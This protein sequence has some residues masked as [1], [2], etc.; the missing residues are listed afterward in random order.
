M[1]FSDIEGDKT[2]KARRKRGRIRRKRPAPIHSDR[3][4]RP[5]HAP[6]FAPRYINSVTRLPDSLLPKV[7]MQI[8]AMSTFYQESLHSADNLAKEIDALRAPDRDK[9]IEAIKKEVVSLITETKTLIPVT[10]KDYEGKT[11][12]QAQGQESS[13]RRH[14]ISALSQSRNQTT[15]IVLSNSNP[16]HLR[17]DSSDCFRYSTQTLSQYSS[18]NWRKKSLRYVDSTH[19][20]S[21]R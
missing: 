16:H 4:L 2:E 12:W 20:R 10:I 17:T 14:S 5:K 3:K 7:N 6:T 13:T 21:I 19:L 8:M 15:S 11:H 1:E 9:F 18:S